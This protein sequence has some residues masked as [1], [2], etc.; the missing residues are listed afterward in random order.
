[1]PFFDPRPMHLPI[2]QAMA[3]AVQ[4]VI[5]GGQYVRGSALERFEKSFATFCGATQGIGVGNGLDALHI[6]LRSLG[7]GPGDEVIVPAN[8][9]VATAL[10]V[11]HAGAVPHFVDVDATT[12]NI[13]PDHFERAIT[14]RTK[15][16][17]P[18]HL[19]GRPCDMGRIMSIAHAHDLHVVEDNAQAH[20]ARWEGRRTGSF[21]QINA[22]SFYPTKNLGALGDAGMLTTSSPALAT[23]ARALSNYGLIGSRLAP[24]PGFNSRLD[25]L[26][27]AIL[28]VKLEHLE[29]WNVER[30]RL[31]AIYEGQLERLPH[32]VVPMERRGEH[33]VYHLYVV[34]SPHRD[35]LRVHLAQHGVATLVHYPVPLHLHAELAY[36]G[37]RPGDH[38]TAELLADTSL[39]LPLFPGMLEQ[40]QARVVDAITSFRTVAGAV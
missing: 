19:Y 24:T 32:I 34:R 15:A 11:V 10:A 26:Q 40:Q 27:A 38:P 20:G 33:G 8:T 30:R 25:E 9:F 13:D 39:S 29:R 16:V 35:A 5:D 14:S 7:V 31:A 12:A 6:A 17:I 1:M 37:G 28:Q 4:R 18:V 36:L 22:T 3:E 23:T 2:K 21:G